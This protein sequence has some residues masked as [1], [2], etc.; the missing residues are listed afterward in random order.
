MDMKVK[1]RNAECR[2]YDRITTVS[3]AMIHGRSYKVCPACDGPTMVVERANATAKGGRKVPRT[4]SYYK[5]GS[6]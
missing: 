6:K 3:N 4:K 1:C 2:M 5:R